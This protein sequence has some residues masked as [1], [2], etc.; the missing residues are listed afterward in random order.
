MISCMPAFRL[1]QTGKLSFREVYH[2]HEN[3]DYD[4]EN[5]LQTFRTVNV[6]SMHHPRHIPTSFQTL[7]PT[8]KSQHRSGILKTHVA[9]L[10]ISL[11]MWVAYETKQTTERYTSSG[12]RVCLVL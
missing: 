10:I 12:S 6:H 4:H 11:N 3:H 5:G 1:N 8:L 7:K 9:L 2:N